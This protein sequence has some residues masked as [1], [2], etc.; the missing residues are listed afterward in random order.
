M[1]CTAWFPSQYVYLGSASYQL[2]YSRYYM[3]YT[4][5][6]DND[7]RTDPNLVSRS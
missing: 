2:Q 5:F 6:L 7:I 1:I 4:I 3:Y